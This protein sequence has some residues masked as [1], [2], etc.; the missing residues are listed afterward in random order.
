M[1]HAPDG[2]IGPARGD[3]M[4]QRRHELTPGRSPLHLWGAELRAWRDRRG[5]SLSMLGNLIRYD[6]S[7]LSRFERGER[8]P[9]ESVARA[10]DDALKAE[11]AILRLW[12]LAEEYRLGQALREPLV[13]TSAVHVANAAPAILN[14]H[15]E[16]ATSEVEDGIIVPCRDLSGRIIWVSVPRRTFLLGAAAGA[17]GGPAISG[18]KS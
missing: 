8:W 2:H 18:K 14:D 15:A 17:V 12:H 1:W 7:H 16:Q 6:P 13:A 5:L 3:G 11:G 4:G 9:P 10:C